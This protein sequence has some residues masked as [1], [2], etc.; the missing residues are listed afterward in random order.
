MNVQRTGDGGPPPILRVSTVFSSGIVVAVLVAL[1]AGPGLSGVLAGH[2]WSPTTGT[3]VAGW[4]HTPADPASSWAHR[5]VPGPAALLYGAVLVVFV[6]EVVVLTWVCLVIGQRAA[7]RGAGLAGP[8]MLRA[9][10][11]SSRAAARKS[12]GEFPNLATDA[13]VRGG[14]IRK[15][16]A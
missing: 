13:V 12:V 2:G 1:W 11:L 4:L 10:G 7:S 14:R 16:P 15:E 8:G 5:P 6:T 3:D 9:S